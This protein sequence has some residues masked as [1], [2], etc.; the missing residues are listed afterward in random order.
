MFGC[1][2]SKCIS[3]INQIEQYG[4]SYQSTV[5]QKRKKEKEKREEIIAKIFLIIKSEK[6][7][8][9]IV[10]YPDFLAEGLEIFYI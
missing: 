5:M 6:Y 3:K 8:A 10:P 1:L 7:Y 4:N 2:F 9:V